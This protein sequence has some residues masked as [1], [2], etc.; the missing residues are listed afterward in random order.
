MAWRRAYARGK[1][2]C[3][4]ARR[5]PKEWGRRGNNSHGPCAESNPLIVASPG[6]RLPR[7][8]PT[9]ISFFP[10]HRRHWPQ[11]A[12]P[13]PSSWNVNS[14][15]APP[16]QRPLASPRPLLSTLYGYPEL[17]PPLHHDRR[18][19]TSPHAPMHRP[20]GGRGC[21]PV[22]LTSANENIARASPVLA[23]IRPGRRGRCPERVCRQCV[24]HPPACRRRPP[25]PGHLA[26]S[27]SSPRPPPPRAPPH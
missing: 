26:P 5:T 4:E 7:T 21:I 8:L 9:N 12:H 22:N 14:K 3:E 19:Q 16:E 11:T 2:G 10:S 1:R 13:L 6:A 20:D 27:G 24:K 23:R 17:N 15:R 25:P 18:V